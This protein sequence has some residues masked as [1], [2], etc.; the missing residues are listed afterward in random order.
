MTM[1]PTREEMTNHRSDAVR[2]TVLNTVDQVRRAKNRVRDR[3]ELPIRRKPIQALLWAAGGA[4]LLGFL[5]GAHSARSRNGFR[6][7]GS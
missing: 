7:E 6:A 5:A 1:T 2:D 4:V 3:I